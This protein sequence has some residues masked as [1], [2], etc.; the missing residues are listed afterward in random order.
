MHVAM[1]SRPLPLQI[2]PYFHHVENRDWP[3]FHAMVDHFRDAGYR[4]VAPDAFCA[5]RDRVAF[6]SF[7]DNYRSFWRALPELERLGIVATFYINTSAFRDRA[8]SSE[9]EAYFDRL[10][11]RG[12]R[13]T[14]SVVE[15]REIAAA[16]HVVGAHGHSHRMLAAL[17]AAQAR[18]D[19]RTSK[20]LLEDLLG[21]EVAH[22]SYPYGMRRHFNEDLRTFCRS[23]GFRTIANGIPGMQFARQRAERI[24]R[25]PWRLDAPLDAN[26]DNLRV[27]G[28]LFEGLTGRSAVG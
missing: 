23:I 19:I 12:E 16:G 26:L 6:L 22:F 8:S 4:F 18:E 13:T 3:A 9:I 1:L 17:P 5:A 24:Q 2:A 25:S 11:F 7:D 27:D 15:L 28:R 14:L 20:R 21:H 10:A